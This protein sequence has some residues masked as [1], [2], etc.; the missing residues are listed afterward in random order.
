MSPVILRYLAVDLNTSVLEQK[1]PDAWSDHSLQYC[2]LSALH[3]SQ[4]EAEGREP[5]VLRCERGQVP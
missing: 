4:E 2:W 3:R 5:P 1:A